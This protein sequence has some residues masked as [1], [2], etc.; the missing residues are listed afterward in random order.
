MGGRGLTSINL[1]YECRII[2]ICQHLLNSTHRNHY[3]KSVV[4][5]EQEQIIRARKERLDRFEIEDKSFLTPKAT[6]KRYL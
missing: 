6:S 2:S 3:L 5:H 1:A 4:E